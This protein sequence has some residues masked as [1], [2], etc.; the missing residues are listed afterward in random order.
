MYIRC[1]EKTTI[2]TARNLLLT[3]LALR[4]LVPDVNRWNEKSL[5]W[6]PS[7]HF[8]FQQLVAM[9]NAFEIEWNPEV[10]VNGK[11][12]KYD[13]PRYASLLDTLHT[14]MLEM[15]PVDMRRSINYG[16]GFGVRSNQ[17][18]DCFSTLFE[19]RERVESLLTFSD[20]VLLASGL[21]FFAHQKTEELNRI[22]RENLDII[23]DILV[24]IIS[25][26]EKQ[27]SMVQMVND[28]GY[29]DVDLCK[30]DLEDL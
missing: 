10:F 6:T 15:L 9:F 8:R 27:F 1:N 17:L 2:I 29:P 18:T 20:G 25:P 7:S 28:Y 19:Y 21:Y 26:E 4:R 3:F 11:F 16:H 22:V 14:S 13:D 5:S 12:I 30:I 24:A 23:D